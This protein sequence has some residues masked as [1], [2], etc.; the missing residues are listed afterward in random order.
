MSLM[1]ERGGRSDSHVLKKDSL[2]LCKIK[3]CR[4]YCN[5]RTFVNLLLKIYGRLQVGQKFKEVEGVLIV[6]YKLNKLSPKSIPGIYHKSNMQK[7]QRHL[8]ISKV[9]ENDK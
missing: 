2:F 4:R 3:L 1:Q 9:K 6:N 7:I 8:K 5:N